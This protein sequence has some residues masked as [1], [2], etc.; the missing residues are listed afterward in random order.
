MRRPSCEA[1]SAARAI[2][3]RPR[4]MMLAQARFTPA[5]RTSSVT[6]ARITVTPSGVT[7]GSSTRPPLS[8]TTVTP[9][10]SSAR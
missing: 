3:A 4:P 6:L 7:T 9:S 5:R 10:P 8:S 1:M 2:R